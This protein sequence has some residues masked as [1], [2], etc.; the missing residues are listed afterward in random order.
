MI[1]KILRKFRGE[2][3]LV[4]MANM[5]SYLV[6]FSGAII[7][8]RMLGKED[9]G[10]YTF[11]F[12]IVSLFLLV[13]GF[14]AA[15]GVL[16]YVSKSRDSNEQ[17]AYL[18][19]AFKSG[20]VFNLFIAVLIILYAFI[21]PLPIANSRSVLLG[22][23]LFPV[24]RLYIDIFQA[25]LRATSQNRLQAKFLIINN[26][27]LLLTNVIGVAIFKLYGLVYFTYIGYILMY[28]IS[29]FKFKLPVNLNSKD[30]I[31]INKKH[32]LS[33]S[34]FTTLS[35][36][37]S[38]LLFIL[39]TIIIGYVLKDAELLAI[40]KV[41]TII[42]FAIT[43]IPNIVV[44][45]H[46]PEFVKNAH[47]KEALQILA[48]RVS[49]QLFIFSSIVSLCLIISA[50]HLILILFGDHYHESILPFQIIAFGYWI[51]ATF[52]T[53]NGN[54]LAALGKAKLSFYLT[55]VILIANV[56]VTYL[57]V[58]FFSIIGAAIAVLFMYAFSSLIG[59]TTLK[60]VLKKLP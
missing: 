7:Y 2:F 3:M 12:G 60:L 31:K 40:Y 25:Y 14:G 22:M 56:F 50:K 37:F 53:V 15:S 39:D 18:N 13:N 30:E 51:L 9:F 1:K 19:F 29:L 4:F 47:N 44:N 24:G 57:M 33:Y 6:A 38:G 52:R 11:A 49:K 26:I 21:V 17:K 42:P 58:H 32:F 28:F 35:N 34:F 46:Y 45:Y 8:V 16:Q 5:F 10:I 43:F 41:A 54:I 59:Y 20:I 55:F 23:A 48:F 36:A 27:I